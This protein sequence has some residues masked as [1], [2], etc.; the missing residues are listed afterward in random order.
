MMTSHASII[1]EWRRNWRTETK[2]LSITGCSSTEEVIKFAI[3]KAHSPSVLR[4]LDT[5]GRST[6]NARKEVARFLKDEI[7]NSLTKSF[8]FD[9]YDAW[10]GTVIEKIRDVYRN[11]H[12]FGDYTYGNAQKLFNMTIKYIL[13]ADNV[14]FNLPIFEVAHIPVDRVIMNV[15]KKKLSIMPMPTAWSKTDNWEDILSYQRRLRAA[16]PKNCPPMVWECE[17]WQS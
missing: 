8:T 3:H 12:G 7:L 11:K 9:E 4:A 5:D 16:L 10:A 17:N 14:D 1:N 6:K 13:S 15:A 2:F